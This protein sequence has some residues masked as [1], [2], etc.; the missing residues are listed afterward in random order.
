MSGTDENVDGTLRYYRLL[1]VLAKAQTTR[2]KY[3]TNCATDMK[4]KNNYSKPLKTPSNLLRTLKSNIQLDSNA[5]ILFRKSKHLIINVHA[6][7]DCKVCLYHIL[8][9]QN[10]HNQGPL[11]TNATRPIVIQRGHLHNSM[12]HF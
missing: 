10:V 2:I 8:S 11:N 4:E 1:V 9:R 7:N 12:P 6:K 5:Y 3:F